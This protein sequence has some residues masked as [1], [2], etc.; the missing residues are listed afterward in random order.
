M[1]FTISVVICVL[2]GIYVL[3]NASYVFGGK[4][5]DQVEEMKEEE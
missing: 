2:T 3:S 4:K 1:I 5:W